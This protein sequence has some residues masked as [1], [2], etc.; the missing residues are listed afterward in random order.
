LF[1]L[2]WLRNPQHVGT[3]VPSSKRL[4]HAIASQ[5]SVS[6]EEYVVELGPGTGVITRALLQVGVPEQKIAVVELDHRFIEQLKRDFPQAVI[7]EGDAR[8]LKE[9]L[10][11]KG[12]KEVA[13]V[14]SGLPLLAMPDRLCHEIVHAVFKVL[15]LEGSF[16]Q[17]T[18]GL[19]SPVSEEHQRRI[20]IRGRVTKRVWRNFLPAKV[21][22]YTS[23]PANRF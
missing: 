2:R 5:V 16:L 10:E 3:P 18:Y 8:H 21:W 15:K 1:F 11:K 22:C 9:L 17:Y 7:I 14:V 20:G 6:P 12:I 23:E 4:A 19:L 13:A